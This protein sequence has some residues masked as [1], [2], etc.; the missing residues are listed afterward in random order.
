MKHAPSL[1]HILLGLLLIV[2]YV[3]PAA[4]HRQVWDARLVLP[5]GGRHYRNPRQNRTRSVF[6]SVNSQSN[7]EIS[8]S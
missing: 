1:W 5:A 7:Q 8:L 6:F 2:T 4:W 3:H